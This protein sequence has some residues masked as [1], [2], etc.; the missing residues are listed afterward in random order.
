VANS[1]EELLRKL[2]GRVIVKG[3][4][5]MA[6]IKP[7]DESKDTFNTLKA[8]GLAGK[9]GETVTVNLEKIDPGLLEILRTG[10]AIDKKVLRFALK[11]KEAPVEELPMSL[12]EKF[13]QT[14]GHPNIVYILLIVGVY[15]L[16]FEVTHPGAVFPGVAGVLCLIV[17]FTA[18]QVIP[19]N[20]VGLLLIAGAFILFLLELKFTSYGLLSAGGVTLM[21]L[22]SLML[23]DTKEQVMK[24]D[25]WL[26]LG[27]TVTTSFLILV[28]LAAVIRTH[29]R[30]VVT[31]IQGM[32]GLVGKAATPVD[33]EGKIF[34]HGEYW[35][36]RSADG[37]SIEKGAGVEIVSLEGMM[38][39]VK[40]KS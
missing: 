26:I 4:P 31:G 3:A 22:G 5:R 40:K 18:F 24:V 17:A 9:P 28:A 7:A 14:I 20:A 16:I 33:P 39:V 37:G 36:A 29:K 13:F 23:V 27:V 11:T 1:I 21:I 30:K 12:R 25:L 8:K 35:N 2:D 10:G 34:V 32:I 38:A 15:A 6:K 19:I